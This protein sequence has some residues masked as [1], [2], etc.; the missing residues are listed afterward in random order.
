MIE[1]H[2]RFSLLFLIDGRDLWMNKGQLRLRSCIFADSLH[3]AR[4]EA[5]GFP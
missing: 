5:H 1:I 4:C 3:G 2:G